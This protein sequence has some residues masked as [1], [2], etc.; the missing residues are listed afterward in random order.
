MTDKTRAELVTEAAECLM[1]IGSGQSLEDE[2]QEKIDSAVD[3]LVDQLSAD[4][5]VTIT[6]TDA[7]PGEYFKALAELLAV[8]VST[9]FGQPYSQANKDI[10]EKQLRR[11][12]AVRPSYEVSQADYF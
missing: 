2:D 10:F 9:K 7:I 4:G 11:T 1:I 5:I 6:D 8:S 12:V 3:P